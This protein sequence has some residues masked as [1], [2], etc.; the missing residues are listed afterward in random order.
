[1]GLALRASLMTQR[2]RPEDIIAERRFVAI[3]DAVLY[4]LGNY[5]TPGPRQWRLRGECVG[6]VFG[7]HFLL[8]NDGRKR[9]DR[10]RFA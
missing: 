6:F 7:C 9:L 10:E 8:R 3:T 5:P 4:K 2:I 1:M